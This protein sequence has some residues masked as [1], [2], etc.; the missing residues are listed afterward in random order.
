LN[1]FKYLPATGVVKLINEPP[2]VVNWVVPFKPDAFPQ[3]SPD[4]LVVF[5]NLTLKKNRLELD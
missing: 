5:S 2:P 4:Q 3:S 1:V